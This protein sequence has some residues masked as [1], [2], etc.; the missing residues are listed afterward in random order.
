MSE[1]PLYSLGVSCRRLVAPSASDREYNNR[2]LQLLLESRS[3]NLALIVFH[4]LYSLDIGRA[5]NLKCER[6]RAGWFLI[7]QVP[8]YSPDVFRRRRVASDKC[9]R[10]RPSAS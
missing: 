6:A 9:I 4:V 10:M 2:F 1:V 8:L 3:Q 5:D 7:S